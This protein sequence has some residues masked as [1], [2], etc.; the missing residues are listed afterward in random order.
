MDEA[1]RRAIEE[2]GNCHRPERDHQ[3]S[4]DPETLDVWGWMTG[5]THFVVSR[6]ALDK[7]KRQARAPARAPRCLRCGGKG[8]VSRDCPW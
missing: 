7:V 6:A 8:H 1:E 3:V 5:C 4:G 2:C